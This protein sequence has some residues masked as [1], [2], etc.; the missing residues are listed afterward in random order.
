MLKV[1]EKIQVKSISVQWFQ[2]FFD[3]VLIELSYFIIFYRKLV[4]GGQRN[5]FAIFLR[6]IINILYN[7]YQIVSFCKKILLFDAI[8]WD[9]F[10][11]AFFMLYFIL[12]NFF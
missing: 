9:L 1:V 11:I 3:Y 4:L 6:F 12:F 8:F 2:T 10:V 5:S 7:K